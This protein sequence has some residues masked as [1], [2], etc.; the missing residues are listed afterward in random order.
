M[1]KESKDEGFNRARSVEQAMTRL[2][3]SSELAESQGHALTAI[4]RFWLDTS[5]N[6][7][8]ESIGAIEEAAKQLIKVASFSQTIYFAAISFGDVKKSLTSLSSGQ[9]WWTIA[10]LVIPLLFWMVSL[11]FAIRVFTPKTYNTN[12]ESPDLANRIYQELVAYKHKRLLIAYCILVAGFVPL[13]I[14]VIL[15]LLLMPVK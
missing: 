6:V 2:E 14:N 11:I 8:K 12:L 13:V 5:R 1:G 10:L 15:Y 4:D 3:D 7:V 9:R